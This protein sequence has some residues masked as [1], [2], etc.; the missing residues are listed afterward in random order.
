MKFKPSQV[1]R[2]SKTS[3]IGPSQMTQGKNLW[4]KAKH[5]NAAFRKRENGAD[6]RHNGLP[7]VFT[8]ARGGG[9][10]PLLPICVFPLQLFGFLCGFSVLSC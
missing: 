7:A 1:K 5:Q 4:S 6:S 9:G 8:T 3:P 2:V 10:F